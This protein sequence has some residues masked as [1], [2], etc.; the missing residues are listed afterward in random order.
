MRSWKCCSTDMVRN[1]KS[2]FREHLKDQILLAPGK[3]FFADKLRTGWMRFNV[4]HCNF[5]RLFNYLA[6]AIGR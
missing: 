6:E 4:A 5:D 3:L 2:I 1:S